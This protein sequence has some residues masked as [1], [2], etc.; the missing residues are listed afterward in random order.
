MLGQRLG[1][2]QQLC[3]VGA[4]DEWLSATLLCWGKG[5]VVVSNFVMLGQRLDG[6]KQLCYVGAKAGWLSVTYSFGA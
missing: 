3:Y 5:G 6:C 4:K 1:G 2:C